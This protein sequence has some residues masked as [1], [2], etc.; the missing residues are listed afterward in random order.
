MSTPVGHG[1][2]DTRAGTAAPPSQPLDLDRRGDR[3]RARASLLRSGLVLHA[4]ALS[5]DLVARRLARGGDDLPALQGRL[6]SAGPVVA[7]RS[8]LLAVTSHALCSEVLRDS[9]LGLTDAQGAPAAQDPVSAAAGAAVVPSFLEL[10]PPD[11]TRLRRLAA[12]AF[13]PAVVRRWASTVEATVDELLARS[14][15]RDRLDV[16]RDLASPLPISVISG[17]LG[18]PEADRAR[19]DEIGLV[20]GQSLDGVRTLSQAEAL[21]AAL[22]ELAALLGRLADERRRE[23]G[24]DVISLL[25]S[26]QDDGRLSADELVSTAGLLLVAGFE[27]TANLIG[28]AVAALLADR[29]EWERLVADPG[30]ADLVVEETLR[31]DPPVQYTVR[32]VQEDLVLA[33]RHLAAGTLLLVDLATAGRDPDVYAGPDVFRPDR[34]AADPARTGRLAEHLAFSSGIHY[35]LGA[36]LARLE[37]GVALRALARERPD[38]RALPGRRRRPGTTLRGFTSLPAA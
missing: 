15:G 33:G 8:G 27:T 24:E 18:V 36:P 21:R 32:L 12:P 7:S 34:W 17:L 14:R 9:R 23:P 3:L 38:L 11:H 19:F 28:N 22:D 5:G 2:P 35:C 37:A 26:A 29:R 6:R 4:L 31:L 10:D 16:V 25:V 13:R 20:V 1:P 30:R